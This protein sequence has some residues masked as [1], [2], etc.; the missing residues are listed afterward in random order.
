M[1]R[2]SLTESEHFHQLPVHGNYK[3]ALL[4]GRKGSCA[5]AAFQRESEI[6]MYLPTQHKHEF[7]LPDQTHTVQICRAH[8]VFDFMTRATTDA[9][10]THEAQLGSLIKNGMTMKQ[11]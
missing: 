1:K 9:A 4:C 3:K 11:T 2:F 8:M 6:Q 5:L 10:E 7:A